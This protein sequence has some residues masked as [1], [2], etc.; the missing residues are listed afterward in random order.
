VL[1]A[2][3]ERIAAIVATVPE[4]SDFALAGG[5]ALIVRGEVDR[6]TRDLDF[7]ATNPAAVNELLPRLEEAL[8]GAGMAVERQQV[9]DG[10]VRLGVSM[11][12]DQTTVDLCYDTRIRPPEPSRL[13]LVMAGEDLAAGKLLALFSRALARDFVDVYFLSDRYGF[14]RLC[15]LAAEKDRGFDLGA[16][17]DALGAMRRLSRDEFDVDDTTFERIKQAVTAWRAAVL[18]RGMD[19]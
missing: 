1:T 14:G 19:Q 17:A 2:L 5:A 8:Q 6:Q 3:Q 12:G 4:A 10:F 7:F 16:L 15:D 11:G 9:R 13:G 18:G